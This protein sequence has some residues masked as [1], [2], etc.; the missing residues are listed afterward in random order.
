MRKAATTK[1]EA[2]KKL[3]FLDPAKETKKAREARINTIV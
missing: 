3:Y 2:E 1:K